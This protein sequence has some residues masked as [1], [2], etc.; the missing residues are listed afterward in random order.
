M[1]ERRQI[2]WGQRSVSPFCLANGGKDAVGDTA[3]AVVPCNW[4]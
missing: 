1:I 2:F 4:I 3:A